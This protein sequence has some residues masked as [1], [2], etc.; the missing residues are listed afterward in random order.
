V[1]TT[2]DY[3]YNGG[4]WGD[5]GWI[6]P[7]AALPPPVLPPVTINLP[8]PPAIGCDAYQTTYGSVIST[9]QTYT[10]TI[11]QPP[12]G[13]M[14]TVYVD[15]ERGDTSTDWGPVETVYEVIVYTTTATVDVVQ[16]T[17][18]CGSNW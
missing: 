18:R 5:P 17:T 8:G 3:G 16:T 4:Y 9:V 6:A 7:W 11:T 12:A 15:P 10:D 1:Y 2:W 13:A 14:V